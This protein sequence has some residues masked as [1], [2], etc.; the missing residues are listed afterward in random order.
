M[1][2]NYILVHWGYIKRES[3]VA[4]HIVKNSGAGALGLILGVQSLSS[5]LN[6]GGSELLLWA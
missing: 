5:R 3:V 1:I 2:F 4:A 6:F